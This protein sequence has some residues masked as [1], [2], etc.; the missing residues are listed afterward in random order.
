MVLGFGCSVCRSTGVYGML[1]PELLEILACPVPE[2]RGT[3]EPCDQAL[4]CT[5]CGRRY[6]I[7]QSWPV[8]IPEKALPPEPR[9]ADAAERG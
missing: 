2:C 4:R 7:E 8:L 6:P 9:A 5:R 3:L 1:R